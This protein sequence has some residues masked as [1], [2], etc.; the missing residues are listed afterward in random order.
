MFDPETDA[1]IDPV[2]AA[3]ARAP[4]GEPYPPEQQAELDQIWADMTSGKMKTVPQAEVQAEVQAW[5][6]QRRAEEA[7]V[8][9]E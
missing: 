7:E 3:I 6:E 2:L 8:A 9:A 5:L 4:V 1:E